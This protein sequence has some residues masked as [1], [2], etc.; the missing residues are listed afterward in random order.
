VY[1]GLLQFSLPKEE[2]TFEVVE[3]KEQE[4]SYNQPN[5]LYV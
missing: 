5:S 3:T 4:D 2:K 1:F